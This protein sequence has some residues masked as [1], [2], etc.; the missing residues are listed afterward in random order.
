MTA[1][2]AEPVAYARPATPEQANRMVAAL[3]Q[4]LGDRPAATQAATVLTESAGTMPAL[5]ADWVA[6]LPDWVAGNAA[7]EVQP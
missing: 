7:S 1:G 4:L 5:V 6:L 3:E 2:L